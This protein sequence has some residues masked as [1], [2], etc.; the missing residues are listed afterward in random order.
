[1][2]LFKFITITKRLGLTLY[3]IAMKTAQ[4]HT[5][6][7][8]LNFCVFMSNTLPRKRPLQDFPWMKQAVVVNFSG[9]NCDYI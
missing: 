5:I 1:M 3:V 9:I 7:L 6:S 8:K 4:F 2:V